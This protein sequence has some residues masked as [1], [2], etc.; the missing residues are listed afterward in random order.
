[1]GKKRVL[2][3]HNFYQIGGGEHTV[4]EN[5]KQLL[6]DRGHE[7]YSYT[8][9]NDELKESKWKLLMM[10][11]STI[12]SAKTYREVRR[13][14]Q[15]KHVD[16]VHCHNTFPLISPSVY[17]AARS[18]RIPVVQTIH[19]FRFICPNGLFFCDGKICEK[20]R[21]LGSFLPALK[22]S[23]YRESKIQTAVVIAM[24]RIHRWLG[25]YR[26][27][28]YIFLTEF[29]KNKFAD[30]IDINEKNVFLKPNF[31]QQPVTEHYINRTPRFLYVGRLDSYKGIDFVLK[32]WSFLPK[33]YELYIY[34][35]GEYRCICEQSAEDQ[36]NIHFM[37]YRP[38]NE[39]F[40]NLRRSSAIVFSSILYEGFPMT[41]A[42][43]FGLGRPA[44]AVNIGNHADIV[45][46]SGG[47]VLYE[48]ENI[49]S[50]CSA[51]EAILKENQKYSENALA[52]Y[53]SQL[54]KEKNY[55]MLCDIYDKAKS[56]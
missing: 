56:I 29:N 24:L 46:T 44:V 13:L 5:E 28:N 42:E 26:K 6:I 38:Q 18:L 25:T 55:E 31:V 51:I 17:Y 30:L 54:T 1:M 19:N 34:G 15:E 4:F 21:E 35:D 14:I 40:G 43:S 48:H 50:F 10:P 8:R 45:R 47:G 32:A 9:S 20:C 16:V 41:L 2:M 37:G 12:W 7:V 3:V 36:P 33:E 52:F 39:I 27:M 49:E 22:N 53:H 23:C 11:F